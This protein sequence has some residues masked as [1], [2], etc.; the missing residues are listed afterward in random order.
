MFLIA[1]DSPKEQSA[2]QK[3]EEL[4]KY[5]QNL[6]IEEFSDYYKVKVIQPSSSD[7]IQFNYV[8]Y[9]NEKPNIEADAFVSIPVKRVI[10]LSTNHLPPFK[11]LDESETIVGFPGIQYIYEEAL[12][13]SAEKGNLRDVGQKSGV[14]IEVLISLQPDLVMGYSMGSSFEQLKPIQ[15]SGI[16]VVL[17]ADYLENSPLGRAEWLKVTAVLLNKYDEG[18]SL[19]RRIEENYLAT[20]N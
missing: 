1:C 3:G 15:K 20:K 14:N 7:S 11:A 16:P 2:V 9:K 18:D 19:F 10:C 5:S 12:L 13:E 6:S 8:L 4:I 17:N